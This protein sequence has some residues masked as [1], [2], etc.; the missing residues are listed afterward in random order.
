MKERAAQAKG[1]KEASQPSL[2]TARRPEAL[3]HLPY[4]PRLECV[5][6]QR[7]TLPT[8]NDVCGIAPTKTLDEKVA[9]A[10]GVLGDGQA[11]YHSPDPVESGERG[12]LGETFQKEK[13]SAQE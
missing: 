11:A 12:L 9:Q 5:Q 13:V 10:Q 1:Y 6:E 4:P 2:A 8:G 7:E 3:D